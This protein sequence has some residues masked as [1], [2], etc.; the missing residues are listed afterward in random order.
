MTGPSRH[1][2]QPARHRAHRFAEMAEALDVTTTQI[3]AVQNPEADH[4]VIVIYLA[5]PGATRSRGVRRCALPRRRRSAPLSPRYADPDNWRQL[6]TMGCDPA[7]LD[8]GM[9]A[10]AALAAE[11]PSA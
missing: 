2:L 4:G 3:L 5:A 11:E 8:R 6:E 10:R 1:K 9:R 7:D